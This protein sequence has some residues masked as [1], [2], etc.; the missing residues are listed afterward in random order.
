M[1]YLMKLVFNICVE[2]MNSLKYGVQ[3]GSTLEWGKTKS[4]L[5]TKY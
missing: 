4:L 2:M 1:E 3:I 5:P